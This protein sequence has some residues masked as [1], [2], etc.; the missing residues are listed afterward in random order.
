MEMGLM[1]LRQSTWV[2]WVGGGLLSQVCVKQA[3][4]ASSQHVG[5]PFWKR[6]TAC[7]STT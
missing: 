7:G 4:R 5:W 1:D 2:I 3:G 6:P